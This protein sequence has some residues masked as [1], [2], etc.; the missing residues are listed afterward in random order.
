MQRHI[1]LSATIQQ[2]KRGTMH[3][4]CPDRPKENFK[5]LKT[6][7]GAAARGNKK[8]EIEMRKMWHTFVINCSHRVQWLERLQAVHL[9]ATSQETSGQF[10]TVGFYEKFRTEACKLLTLQSTVVNSSCC[11]PIFKTRMRSISD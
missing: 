2:Q 9:K 6:R 10:I 8:I 1:N 3:A 7:R 4:N 5:R 11:C